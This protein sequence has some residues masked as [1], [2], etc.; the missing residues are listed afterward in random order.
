MEAG[1]HGKIVIC[2]AGMTG[3]GKSTDIEFSSPGFYPDTV[4]SITATDGLSVT[5]DMTLQPMPDVPVLAFE[6]DNLDEL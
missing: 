3:C 4:W 2:V 6:A 1:E 5:V